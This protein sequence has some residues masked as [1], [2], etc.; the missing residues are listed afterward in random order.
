MLYVETLITRMRGASCGVAALRVKACVLQNAGREIWEQ[1]KRHGNGRLD[2]F[3]CGAGTGGTIAGV[4]RYLKAKDPLIQ[5][6]LADPP[7]SSLYNK[8]GSR[9]SVKL[10]RNWFDA[11]EEFGGV[12][13]LVL[14]LVT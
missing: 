2:A 14:V 11:T 3:V 9:N 4:S 8:V 10:G 12:A 1:T 6:C 5:V 7:G 13:K